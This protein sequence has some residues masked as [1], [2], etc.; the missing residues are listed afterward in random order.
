MSW[1]NMPSS[2]ML[3]CCICGREERVQY[4]GRAH[5]EWNETDSAHK[6]CEEERGE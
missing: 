3:K 1:N 4:G 2:G 5:E 6:E